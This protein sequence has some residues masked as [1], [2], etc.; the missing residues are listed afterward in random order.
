MSFKAEGL[1]ARNFKTWRTVIALMLREMATSYGRSPGGY[2]WAIL[3]PVGGLAVM[4]IAFS[5]AFRSPALGNNFPLFYATGFL[6][7]MMYM[8]VSNKISNSITFSRQLL[9]YPSVTYLDA[10]IARLLLNGLTQLLVFYML[11]YGLLTIFDTGNILNYAAILNALGMALVLAFGVGVMNCFL[12][13]RFPIWQRVWSI[14]TRPLFII[15]TIFFILESIPQPFRDYLA[16]NP[17]V[18]V[19][20]EMRRGFYATYDATWVN[21]A[22]VYG[23]GLVLATLGLIFLAR[24]H[25]EILNR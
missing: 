2:L 7:F 18:H 13:T 22:F 11:M 3:E 9:F 16:L 12:L 14:I 8:D 15:S 17:L 6:P 21:P 24:Y 4:T 5:M 1:H 19:V 23:V 20:G 25:R 10:I